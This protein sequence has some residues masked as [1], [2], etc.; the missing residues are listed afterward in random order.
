MQLSDINVSHLANIVAEKADITSPVIILMITG[1]VLDLIK[2]WQQCNDGELPPLKDYKFNAWQKTRIGW[3]V[4]KHLGFLH[5][6][7]YSR[8]VDSII[9]NAP[10]YDFTGKAY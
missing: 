3:S 9:E 10:K 6:Q 4:G 8:I 7:Y 1:I 5:Y 2:I